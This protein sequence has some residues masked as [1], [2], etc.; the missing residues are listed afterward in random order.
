MIP[1]VTC[2]AQPNKPK[3][4]LVLEAF[5]AGCGGRM[6]STSALVLEPGPAAFYGVRQGWNTLWLQ[7]KADG[8]DWYYLD[9]AYFDDSRELRFRVGK[10]RV[11]QTEFPP[12]DYPPFHRPIAPWRTEGEHIVICPQSEEFMRVVCVWSKDW[13]EHVL[14]ELRRHTTRPLM[15]RRKGDRRTL[16]EDLKGA[17]ALVTH[18]SA[19]ANEA[20]IAGIPVFVTGASSAA[21]L[22]GG[23]LSAIES[24][25]CPDGREQWAAALAAH[26][27]TLDELR[28]GKCWSLMN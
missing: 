22:A 25:L 3:S 16:A 21:V 14:H 13:A 26:Q 9:N 4:R 2:Y 19:A 27:F 23:P 17:W 5:A 8:R 7:A 20:I 15:V 1:S 28:E 11:Q 12:G 18:S 10:N 6:A 24:P